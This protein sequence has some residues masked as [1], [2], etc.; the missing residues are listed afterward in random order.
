MTKSTVDGALNMV[1]PSTL[2]GVTG[3]TGISAPLLL[4]ILFDMGFRRVSLRIDRLLAMALREV[5]MVRRFLVNAGFMVLGRFL[6]M[7]RGVLVMLGGFL[8]MG[9]CLF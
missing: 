4:S 7:T 1:A 3:R 5:G 6:M 9:C 2:V 8:V